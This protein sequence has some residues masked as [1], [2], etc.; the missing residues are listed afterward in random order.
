[1]GRWQPTSHSAACV[2]MF[3]DRAAAALVAADR[4]GTGAGTHAAAATTATAGSALCWPRWTLR[5]LQA[6]RAPAIQCVSL[7]RLA[8]CLQVIKGNG[9]LAGGG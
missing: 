2:L 9:A 7:G 4:A 1:M 6:R 8:R 3:A 5:P